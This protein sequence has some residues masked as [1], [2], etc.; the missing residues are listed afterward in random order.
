VAAAKVFQ[1]KLV[2]PTA[3]LVNEPV[4]YASVPA[5]DGLMGFLPGRAPMLGRLGVGELR[6]DFPDTEKGEGASRSFVI[7][8]GVVRMDDDQMTILAEQAIPAEE[9]STA[10]AE[11]ELKNA[12]DQQSAEFARAKLS[13]A[14][15]G[16][17]I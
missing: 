5:W 13:L 11:A 7:S 14:Q 10:A 6:L 4:T 15:R 8:G 3:A 17:G 12:K 2:T 9:I 16:K 1:C